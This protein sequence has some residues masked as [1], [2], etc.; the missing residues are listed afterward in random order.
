MSR[1]GFY[2]AFDVAIILLSLLSLSFIRGHLILILLFII[3]CIGFNLSYNGNSLFYSL[4]GLRE[5]VNVLFV[6]IFLN[7][8]F[9]EENEDLAKEYVEIFKKFSII[10]LAFQLPAAT[11]QFIVHGPSDWV[12]GTYGNFGSGN[13]TLSVICLV[14]FLSHFTQ[15]LTQRALLYACLLP[16]FLNET[17]ISFILIPLLILFIHFKPK[18]KSIIG[19]GFAAALSLFIFS[20]Y[21]TTNIGAIEGDVGGI[22]RDDFIDDYLFGDIYSSTDVPRFTKIVVGWQLLAEDIKTFLFGLEYGI[23][24]GSDMVE[25]SQ[26]SQSV[27]WLMTGTRPYLFF[28]MIQGGILL[29]AGIM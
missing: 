29:F 27:E 15:N 22:F 8:I 17:K 1:S 3:A 2:F 7:H 23:F 5:I 20:Q 9:L 14:F 4:N 13:L 11:Y 28:L 25:R 24:R 21:F 10:F 6:A 19:A 26:F 16:L 18:I 12:G